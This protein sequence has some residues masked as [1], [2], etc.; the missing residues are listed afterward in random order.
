MHWTWP[1]TDEQLREISSHLRG[2]TFNP[3]TSAE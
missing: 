3:P 1:A 2:V